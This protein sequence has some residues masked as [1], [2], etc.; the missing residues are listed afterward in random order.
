[1]RGNLDINGN[2]RQIIEHSWPHII[3]SLDDLSRARLVL[4][5]IEY[6]H[7][8]PVV[9]SSTKFHCQLFR[10]ET[11]GIGSSQLVNNFVD[12]LYEFELII[13]L[14]YLI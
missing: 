5:I 6:S 2:T 12:A 3:V 10:T 7:P 13:V 1:M 8:R 11:H 9:N 4:S 14:I